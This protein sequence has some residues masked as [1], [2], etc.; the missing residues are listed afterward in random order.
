LFFYFNNIEKR[1]N[2]RVKLSSPLCTDAQ[3]MYRRAG[4]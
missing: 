1:R 3:T 4:G 2:A